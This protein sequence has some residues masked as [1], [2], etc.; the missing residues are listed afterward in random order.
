M[1]VKNGVL[2]LGVAAGVA[3]FAVSRIIVSRKGKS[4]LG[5]FR[6]R[7]RE[8][9]RSF[10]GKV[11]LVTGGSRG[12]GLALAE[13]YGRRGARLILTAR[14]PEELESARKKLLAA[15]I[16]L[17]EEDVA[18][19]PCDLTDAE[20]TK[21][22]MEQ[23]EARF[24]GID[25]LV[26][27]AGIIS[28]GPVENQSLAAFR[29]AMD[30]N[31]YTMLHT[32]L[33]VLPQ[34]LER[35]NGSIVN[36]TSIGAKLA[37]PHLLPYSASKFAALGFSQG[38][39]A[40]LRSKGI[41]VTTVC[42]GLMR[43]GSHTHALFTGDRD[44]EYRWFSLSASLPFLSTSA[45]SAARQV[46]QATEEGRTEITITPQALLVAT[47]AQAFPA[48][49]A[50]VMHRV[51]ALALPKPLNGSDQSL[52]PG[53][54]V[55]GKELMPFLMLGRQ[56]ARRYNEDA[57]EHSAVETPASFAVVGAR[58]LHASVTLGGA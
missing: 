58:Q 7:R 27:N 25:V 55:R 16:G 52:V 43:T 9:S 2:G 48:C 40:E 6:T 53:R 8:V 49:T 28:V 56:A 29:G 31:F 22:M 47:L 42:P 21:K 36:I 44:R 33:A 13:E 54:D 19:F 46:V 51:T 4:R 37:V 34:M 14:N 23:A 30:S 10:A 26:N 11:V 57:R 32:T 24:G 41:R 18:T 1:K 17:R 38:L 12:F 3:L 45:R 35:R 15:K 20:Q 5:K 39:H 50:A